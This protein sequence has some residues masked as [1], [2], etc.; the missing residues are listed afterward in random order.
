MKT[1][2][3]K[4]CGKIFPLTNEFFQ[5]RKGAK[6][7]F[8]NDC[9]KCISE[10]K[11]QYRKKNI[12]ILTAKRKERYIRN[13]ERELTKNKEYKDSHKDELKQWF[14]NNYEKNK[15][16][17]LKRNKIYKENN[18]EYFK[19]KNK[20]YREKNKE[21]ISKWKKEYNIINNKEISIKRKK[22]R[23]EHLEECRQQKNI[24]N[25]KRKAL[26]RSL[27]YTLT[28]NEWNEIKNTFN[29]ECAYC[30]EKIELQMDH[31]IPLSRGGEFTK[32]NII[33]AC[34]RCNISKFNND[35]L[36]W[37]PKQKFY[38]K[39]QEKFILEYLGY[40]ED[41]QQLKLI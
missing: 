33:P 38:S 22:Y 2:T 25:Q 26:K 16:K 19:K 24:S 5:P 35:F 27:P 21:Y 18:K 32:N 7:G 28:N 11:K 34:R 36:K 17:I 37:Y 29:Y 4:K 20:E 1:K 8:R 3:C 14:K 12:E 30:R 6:D 40:K 23:E 10:Y 15:E 9:K 31:F 41:K 39:E 13:K